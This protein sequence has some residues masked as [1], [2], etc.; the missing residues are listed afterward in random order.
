MACL[1][2]YGRING[3]QK[4]CSGNYENGIREGKWY[5]QLDNDIQSV[6]YLIQN[7]LS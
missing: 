2:V 3:G 1:M 5:F 6:D 4:L 7:Y